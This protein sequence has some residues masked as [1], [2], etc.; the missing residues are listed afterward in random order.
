MKTKITRIY[1]LR[2]VREAIIKKTKRQ[3][4][5][6]IERKKVCISLMEIKDSTEV[7]SSYVYVP[8]LSLLNKCL[9]N[10]QK[11]RPGFISQFITALFI[12]T[13][14]RHGINQWI[15]KIW[16]KHMIGYY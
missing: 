16:Y 9:Q 1:Y 8:A 7:P 13:V 12:R 5:V 15:K 14:T 6:R 4:Q 10:K 11:P 3:K 2:P